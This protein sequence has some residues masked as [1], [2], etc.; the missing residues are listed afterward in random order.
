MKL[1]ALRN[2]VEKD[3]TYRP[4]DVI[5][6]GGELYKRR[7][8]YAK[9]GMVRIEDSVQTVVTNVV[10]IVSDVP[11]D[12]IAK[13]KAAAAAILG[14]NRGRGRKPGKTL[15]TKDITEGKF[16]D[17]PEVDESDEDN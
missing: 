11:E 1:V 8:Y 2:L 12:A 16:G 13:A 9:I 10:N 17:T 7:E 3:K 6:E 14:E 4:G 5:E 15:T